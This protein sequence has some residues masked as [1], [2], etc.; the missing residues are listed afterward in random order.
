MK[1]A[2]PKP[3]RSKRKGT[4]TN[5]AGHEF[6]HGTVAHFNRRVEL[7]YRAGGRLRIECDDK[8]RVVRVWTVRCANCELC[9]NCLLAWEGGHWSHLVHWRHCDCMGCS[10]FC[11]RACHAADHH[12]DGRIWV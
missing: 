5:K 8:N 2:F 11:C 9:K 6:L 7:F 3:K 4:R 12:S 1:L 10:A